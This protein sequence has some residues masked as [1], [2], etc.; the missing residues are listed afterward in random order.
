MKKT[1]KMKSRM[2]MLIY[3]ILLLC[4]ITI[5]GSC[6][7]ETTSNE[8]SIRTKDII[9]TYEGSGELTKYEVVRSEADLT[10]QRY[11]F[12]SGNRSETEGKIDHLVFTFEEDEKDSIWYTN[13]L[14]GVSGTLVYDAATTSWTTQMDYPLGTLVIA[15]AFSKQN[16]GIQV[17]ITY[18][19]SFE[20]EHFE[21]PEPSDGINEFTMTLRKIT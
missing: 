20:R 19:Q 21:N 9:G 4:S 18:T 14:T 17:R 10:N 12:V 13:A 6:S 5:L 15:A 16:D 3:S 2:M 11:L 8:T 7:K 1:M